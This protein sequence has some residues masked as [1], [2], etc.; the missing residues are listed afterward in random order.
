MTERITV[1]N[2]PRF[3]RRLEAIEGNILDEVIARSG[4]AK[5]IFRITAQSVLSGPRTG[6]I[7]RLPNGSR[8]QASAPGE[9]PTRKSGRLHDELKVDVKV[10]PG[11]IQT[12]DG[13]RDITVAL[14]LESDREASDGNQ[15]I[16]YLEGGTSRMAP[17][18]SR[19]LIIKKAW[20]FVMAEFNRRYFPGAAR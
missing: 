7:Y 17:R 6:R 14:Q 18:P 9:P 5:I 3:V 10:T 15:L 4:R 12:W 11:V 13:G 19:A 16:Q 8:Y 2:Y 1:W 20:P